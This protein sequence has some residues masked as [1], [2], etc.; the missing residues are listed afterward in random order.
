M[1]A[2]ITQEEFGIEIEMKAILIVNKEC[3]ANRELVAQFN[4]LQGCSLLRSE[5][6]T[7][8]ERMTAKTTRTGRNGQPL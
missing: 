3:L 4:R 7:G 6:R 2:E 8:I 5:R 1:K